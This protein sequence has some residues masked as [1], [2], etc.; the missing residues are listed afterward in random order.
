MLEVLENI[1]KLMNAMDEKHY[2]RLLSDLASIIYNLDRED[3]AKLSLESYLEETDYPDEEKA[4]IKYFILN[5]N[6]RPGV[7]ASVY[8]RVITHHFKINYVI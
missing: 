2:S 4:I 1:D 7:L 8:S 5:P 6:I 3:P